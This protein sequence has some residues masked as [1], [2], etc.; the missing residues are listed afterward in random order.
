MSVRSSGDMNL[1]CTGTAVSAGKYLTYKTLLSFIS[2]PNPSLKLYTHAVKTTTSVPLPRN[3][4]VNYKT[5]FMGGGLRL[6]SSHGFRVS[7][8]FLEDKRQG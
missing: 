8:G 5:N 4:C 2:I 3:V 1:L 6:D 7:D